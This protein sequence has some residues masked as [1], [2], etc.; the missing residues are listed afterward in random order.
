LTDNAEIWYKY[1]GGGA[2]F[3]TELG[4]YMCRK[5]T[6]IR[7]AVVV[8]M[9]CLSPARP[10]FGQVSLLGSWVTDPCH[11]KE[12][13]S[14]RL[15]VVIGHAEGGTTSDPCLST[16]TY[17]GQTMTKI[18][19]KTQTW[20]GLSCAYVAVFI[21]NEAGVGAASGRHKRISREC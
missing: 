21:L 17:G 9:V 18:A 2:F 5:L 1:R 4:K 15:L 12:A 7:L 14:N 19:A 3:V 8:L 6:Y 20:E 13:G 11:T 16:V 10:A